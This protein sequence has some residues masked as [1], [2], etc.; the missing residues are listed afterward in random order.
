V[1]VHSFAGV[2]L[3]PDRK[4]HSQTGTCHEPDVV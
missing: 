1:I 2:G 3:L 4:V